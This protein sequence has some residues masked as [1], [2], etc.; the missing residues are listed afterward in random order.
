[1]AVGGR[2]NLDEEMR[3]IVIVARQ[4][5]KSGRDCK[6]VKLVGPGHGLVRGLVGARYHVAFI[7]S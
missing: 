1:M 7:E 4:R 2:G 5:F 6:R 3:S